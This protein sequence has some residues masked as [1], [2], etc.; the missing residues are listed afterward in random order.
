MSKL[1]GGIRPISSYFPSKEKIV[2]NAE[3]ATPLIYVDGD[4]VV[5]YNSPKIN[6]EGKVI[7]I[8]TNL[9]L[10][11]SHLELLGCTPCIFLTSRIKYNIDNIEELD[12]LFTQVPVNQTSKS[13][14]LHDAF[15][16]N[17]LFVSNSRFRRYWSI[18][19]T[20]E[21]LIDHQLAF[22]IIK[23]QVQL[24]RPYLTRKYHTRQLFTYWDKCAIRILKK[25]H[26]LRQET[27]QAVERPS[28]Y[29]VVDANDVAMCNSQVKS[30]Q[31]HPVGK[32]I[33]L[34][35]LYKYLR[36]HHWNPIFLEIG[37]YTNIDH[38][39]Q[40][41]QLRKKYTNLIPYPCGGVDY[42]ELLLTTAQ[43]LNAP[44]LSNKKYLHKQNVEV[45]GFE[46]L[47]NRIIKLH[48]PRFKST[49]DTMIAALRKNA[50][51][52]NTK[53]NKLQYTNNTRHEKR[54]LMEG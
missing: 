9:K 2:K 50:H 7:G 18:Q 12:A 41:D 36:Q 49:K 20:K 40:F 3:L 19:L 21:R 26:Q 10:I 42:H 43:I 22:T 30:A 54:E 6:N 51:P 8:V 39:T 17:A 31:G 44:I 11:K 53:Q 27:T 24:Y 46:I 38:P 15:Q 48:A 13:R 29:I 14:F 45:Y 5:R 23:G 28:R 47:K 25:Q 35:L 16:K 32:L 33:N 1:A 34:L 52:S 4:N 37:L